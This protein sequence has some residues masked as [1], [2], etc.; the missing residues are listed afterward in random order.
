MLQ[1]LVKFRST[2]IKPYLI[3]QSYQKELKVLEEPQNKGP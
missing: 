2:V 1:E 3:K